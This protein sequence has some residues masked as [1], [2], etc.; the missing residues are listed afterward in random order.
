MVGMMVRI[1]G[2]WR[3]WWGCGENVGDEMMMWYEW[4]WCYENDCYEVRMMWILW[5]WGECG[6]N[7]GDETRMRESGYILQMT[8]TYWHLAA[9]IIICLST[10]VW[11]Y[12]YFRLILEK[13]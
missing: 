6:E 1:L 13:D 3:E 7:N 12:F 10:V 11:I 8:V 4:W 9:S 2:T 5:E